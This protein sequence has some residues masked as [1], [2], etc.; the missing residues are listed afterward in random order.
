MHIVVLH[1]ITDPDEFFSYDA[2]EVSE[3]APSDVQ[4]RQFFPSQD[5]TSAVCL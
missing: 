2:Q 3:N 1:R 5:K 4:A